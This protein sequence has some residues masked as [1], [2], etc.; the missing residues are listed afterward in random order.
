[1]RRFM[2]QGSIGI[3]GFAAAAVLLLA[4][5]AGAAPVS[6]GRITATSGILINRSTG[7]IIWERNP[8]LQLPPASTTKVLTTLIALESARLNDTVRVSSSASMASPSK[9]YLQPGWGMRV[10]D[11]V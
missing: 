6:L 11:L 1:M 7:E 8:D 5:Y 9:L 2:R 10:D 3:T 4:G